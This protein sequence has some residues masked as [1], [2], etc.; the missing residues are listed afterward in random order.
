[1]KKVPLLFLLFLTACSQPVLDEMEVRNDFAPKNRIGMRAKAAYPQNY[2]TP[3][4]LTEFSSRLASEGRDLSQHGVYIESFE[5]GEPIAMMNEDVLFN[6][7]SV[8]K[9]ATTLAALERLGPNRAF[10]TDFLGTGEI[11]PVSGELSGDLVLFAGRDPAFSISDT[12]RVG[13]ALRSLGIRQVAGS[14]VVIGDFSCN[15]KPRTDE[16]IEIFLKNVGVGF[17]G[18]VKF[19]PEGSPR[20]RLLVT[21]ESD[22][23]LHIVQYL[24][25]HSVNSIADLLAAH[26]GGTQSVKRILVETAGLAPEDVRI[27]RASG[28]EV[29]RLSPRDTVKVLRALFGRLKRYDLDPQAVMAIAGVDAGTLARR[30]TEREFAGSVIAKT[31]TLYTTDTGVAALAGVIHTRDKGDLLFAI[32]DSAQYRRIQYLRNAQD[33]FLKALMNECG[34]PA[35][36][37]EH[38]MTH[39]FD[40]LQ[41]NVTISE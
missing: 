28:L 40:K 2:V 24:N 18:P 30:F 9:L 16:S 22:S 11:S 26:I 13:E 10:H 32:Y 19:E 37:R 36:S 20:G 35:P 14:L 33:D 23:L 7:A 27:S 29:N 39:N 15:F 4:S 12:K 3:R 1:M 21:V 8:M 34:G 41:S 25:A 6:P 17:R 38:S 31:G 5:T